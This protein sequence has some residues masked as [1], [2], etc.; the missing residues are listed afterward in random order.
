M[1]LG[2]ARIEAEDRT[3]AAAPEEQDAIEAWTAARGA[4]VKDPP[5]RKLGYERSFGGGVYGGYVNCAP[6]AFRLAA[7]TLADLRKRRTPAADVR[8]WVKAQDAVFE[9]CT[10]SPPPPPGEKA[11][12][13]P[14][15]AE[16]DTAPAPAAPAPLEKSA[17]ASLRQLRD[18]QVAAAWFYGGQH[19]RARS[20][21]QLIARTK[22]HPL[23]TWAA[24]AALRARLREATLDLTFDK[25]WRA[26]QGLAQEERD[27]RLR[28]AARVTRE[29]ADA[30]LLGIEGSV[31]EVL[32]TPELAPVHGA[33]R[34][35]LEQAV[36]LLDA[37]R[38]FTRLTE[39]L[40]DLEADPYPQ[41]LP[42]RWQALSDRFAWKRRPDIEALRGRFPF[43]DWIRTIQR[44]TDNP[45]SPNAGDCAAEHR[46]ALQ[47][48]T[49]KKE[50][51][52]L[53]AV[54]MT[55]R[56]ITPEDVPALD[57]AEEVPPDAPERLTLRYHAARLL[58][59]AGRAEEVRTIADEVLDGG[60]GLDESATA[61]FLQLRLSVTEDMVAVGK[62]LL[63]PSARAALQGQVRLGIDGDT[64]LNRT[65]S[66][67]D[68][69]LLASSPDVP[70]ALQRQLLVAAW[71]RADVAG[72]A[73][74]ALAAAQEVERGIPQ[75]APA[76]RQYAAARNPAA[77]R[78]AMAISAIRFH[79]SPVVGWRWGGAASRKAFGDPRTADVPFSN[80]CS[81]DPA[82]FAAQRAIER[83]PPLPAVKP[84]AAAAR[85]Q[86]AL[87]EGGPW[88]VYLARLALDPEAPR[89][90]EPRTQ[91][92]FLTLARR[93]LDDPQ[94]KVR[95]AD[96]LKEQLDRRLQAAP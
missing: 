92:A 43:L 55:A 36:T 45:A 85:E 82:D 61:L 84:D 93:S 16:P 52:W 67:R 26:V 78:Y 70:P 34:N 76:A 54:I 63:R 5:R 47:V 10:W 6:G 65:L 22:G 96:P 30:A 33:A 50:R 75:L 20:A 49:E 79:L 8:G 4:I 25:E 80:W 89:I 68:L 48:W 14:A 42:W 13:G 86:R 21:F 15:P 71:F 46:H 66:S 38:A 64:L 77:R 60:A 12:P 83:S 7:E 90:L 94:C 27:R 24:V 58:L 57:A 9:F 1:A 88:S 37:P 28:E 23:R 2:R 44:C 91:R 35:L 39:R 62:Y 51:A 40:A 87:R 56:Q 72:E 18:Y 74:T 3:P 11:A 31:E 32:R 41:D 69:L 95:G 17:S 53:V 59:E 73:A 81:F 19:E 29:R